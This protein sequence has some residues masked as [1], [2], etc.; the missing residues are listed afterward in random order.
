ML[1][2]A[3]DALRRIRPHVVRLVEDRA[4]QVGSKMAAYDDV[5]R[6]VGASATWVQRV[7][8]RRGG[9]R[10]V[11]VEVDDG[12]SDRVEV[13][14][15]QGMNIAAAIERLSRRVEAEAETARVRAAAL[16]QAAADSVGALDIVREPPP[17]ARG[18]RCRMRAPSAPA[19]VFARVSRLIDF[20]ALGRV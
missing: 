5:A 3:R 4:R 15:A 10:P 11:Q 6:E 14:L 20:P 18:V 8:G 2:T 13:S 9:V 7:V 16:R 1:V 12:R 17:A 19:S